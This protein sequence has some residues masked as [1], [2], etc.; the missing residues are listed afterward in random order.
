LSPLRHNN[1]KYYF[2]DLGIRNALI[3]FRQIEQTHL[4]ENL[5]YNEL[6]LRG[7]EVDF[8]C[9]KGYERVYI[10]SALNLP[11]AEKQTQEMRPLLS[12]KDSFKKVVLV[13]GLQPTYMTDDGVLVQNLFDFL[14]E[15]DE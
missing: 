11:T 12:I 10:Q 7:Y 14:L 3:N 15:N 9:N 8:V 13:G 6:R 1:S 5:I 2:E 4:M